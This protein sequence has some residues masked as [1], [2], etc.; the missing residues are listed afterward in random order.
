LSGV[1]VIRTARRRPVVVGTLIEAF[2]RSSIGASS[3][4]SRFM[5][6]EYCGK[7]AP[8][9]LRVNGLLAGNT[10]GPPGPDAVLGAG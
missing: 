6:S 5:P 2:S 8:A 10:V 7:P 1:Q 4:A 9:A 3:T